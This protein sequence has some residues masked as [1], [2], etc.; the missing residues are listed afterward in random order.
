MN[1]ARTKN[2]KKDGR[3]LANEWK[4]SKQIWKISQ[5]YVFIMANRVGVAVYLAS[6]A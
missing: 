2:S 1:I 3:N 5:P 6:V 4:F